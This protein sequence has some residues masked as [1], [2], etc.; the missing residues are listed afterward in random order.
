MWRPRPPSLSQGAVQVLSAG[1][2]LEMGCFLM[3]QTRIWVL[4]GMQM[5][6]GMHGP[7]GYSGTCLSLLNAWEWHEASCTR[8]DPRWVPGSA[9]AYE[10]TGKCTQLYKGRPHRKGGSL[11][12]AAV[13]LQE[14]K[15][16]VL[17]WRPSLFP[18][19]RTASYS[20][21]QHGC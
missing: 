11:V 7:V 16:G 20:S 3:Q 4:R 15:V 5:D 14:T 19:G 21:N 6:S 12:E 18:S 2:I 13:R 8:E 10:E 1:T 9:R 17:H